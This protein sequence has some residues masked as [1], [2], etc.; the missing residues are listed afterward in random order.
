MAHQSRTSAIF[1]LAALAVAIT[2]L[3][4][5]TRSLARGGRWARNLYSVITVISI[6]QM[7]RTLP[8]DFAHATSLGWLNIA[9]HA[10]GMLTLGL[11]FTRPA[12]AWF[13]AH[14]ETEPT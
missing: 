5:L 11:L 1:T 12:N 2:F 9:A 8:V 4:V 14:A 10:L 7:Y 13:G 6:A 3:G